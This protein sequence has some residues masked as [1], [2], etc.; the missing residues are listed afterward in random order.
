MQRSKLAAAGLAAT[1]LTA[2]PVTIAATAS[3]FQQVIDKHSLNAI[4]VDLQEPEYENSA[5]SANELGAAKILMA[6]NPG[7]FLSVTTAGT[8]AGTGFFGTQL[9]DKARSIGFNPNN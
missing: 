3:G 5:A 4:D 8:A 2:T 6:N 9:L 1:V 7:L